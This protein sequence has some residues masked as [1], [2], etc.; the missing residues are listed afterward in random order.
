MFPRTPW[1]SHTPHCRP[2]RLCFPLCS[3]CVLFAINWCAIGWYNM[4][5][6]PRFVKIR[7]VVSD[8]KHAKR[9]DRHPYPCLIYACVDTR[10]HILNISRPEINSPLSN[11]LLKAQAY[12]EIS[13]FVSYRLKLVPANYGRP[14]HNHHLTAT[15]VIIIITVPHTTRVDPHHFLLNK[16]HLLCDAVI[17][18]YETMTW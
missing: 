8:M 18:W 9:A 5:R 13:L 16:V 12:D 2:L 14:T 6:I 1:G 4:L 3:L 7:P 11:F 10:A 15:A 17:W